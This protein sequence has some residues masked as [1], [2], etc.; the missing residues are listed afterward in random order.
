MHIQFMEKIEKKII[1]FRTIQQIQIQIQ[2]K[3]NNS[4]KKLKRKKKYH[5][6]IRQIKQNAKNKW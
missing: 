3:Y 1:E 2:L 5:T 4:S 6:E